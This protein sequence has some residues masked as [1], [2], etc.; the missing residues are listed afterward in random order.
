[1]HQLRDL[2]PFAGLHESLRHTEQHSQ[3]NRLPSAMIAR[4]VIQSDQEGVWNFA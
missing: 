1:M 3:R 2:I 4:I